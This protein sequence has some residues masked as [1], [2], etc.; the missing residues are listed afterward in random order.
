MS[1]GISPVPPQR[2]VTCLT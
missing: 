2:M 1:P